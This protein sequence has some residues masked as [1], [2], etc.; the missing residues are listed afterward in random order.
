MVIVNIVGFVHFVDDCLR[1][2]FNN[3]KLIL[4]KHANVSTSHQIKIYDSNTPHIFH[5]IHCVFYH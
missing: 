1:P 3:I 4:T 5:I 2:D